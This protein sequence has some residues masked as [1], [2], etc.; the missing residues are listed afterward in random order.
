M[1]YN[2]RLRQYWADLDCAYFDGS[3]RQYDK[4][5]FGPFDSVIQTESAIKTEIKQAEYAG[6]YN[7]NRSDFTIVT[8]YNI[9]PITIK[10]TVD[11]VCEEGDIGYII[12]LYFDGQNNR[13]VVELAK[14]KT[15]AI[16][17]DFVIYDIEFPLLK[18]KING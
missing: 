13:A 10:K 11:G 4:K 8:T 2:M 3:N 1:D 17:Y 9:P 7:W 12:N 18:D 14:P 5:T 16:S 15:A 6:N